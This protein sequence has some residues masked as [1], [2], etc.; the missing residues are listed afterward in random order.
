MSANRRV[1][2]KASAWVTANA[3]LKELAKRPSK[4][5]EFPYR[6]RRLLRVVSQEAELI[7]QARQDVANQFVKRDPTTNAPIMI[8]HETPALT[9]P[10]EFDVKIK[11]LMDKV[12]E[13][14]LEPLTKEELER[15]GLHINGDMCFNLGPLLIDPLDTTPDGIVEAALIEPPSA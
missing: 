5:S 1:S 8:T 6:M 10:F 9:D 14:V 12:I 4:S 11:G 3:Y 7:E 13:L 2:A 15:E